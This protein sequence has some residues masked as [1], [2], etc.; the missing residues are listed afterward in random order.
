MLKFLRT[1]IKGKKKNLPNFFDLPSYKQK[2]IIRKAAR[3]AS[4]EQLELVKRHDRKLMGC[5]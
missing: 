2:K 3:E 5:R 4:E 1:T